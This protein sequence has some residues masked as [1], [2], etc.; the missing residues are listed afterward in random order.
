MAEK[1]VL[2]EVKNLVKKYGTGEATVFALNNVSMKVYK[3]EFLI[4]TKL[5]QF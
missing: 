5:Y 2:I 4:K 3:G 1:E